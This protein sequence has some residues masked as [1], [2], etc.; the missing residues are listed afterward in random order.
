MGHLLYHAVFLQDAFLQ[1]DY[2]WVLALD[3]AKSP[4]FTEG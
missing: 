1:V 3:A 2:V 4:K